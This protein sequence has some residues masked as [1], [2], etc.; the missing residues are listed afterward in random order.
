MDQ[1]TRRIIGFATHRGDVTGV[2]LCCLFNKIIS[3]KSLPKYLSSDNDPLFT[4]HRW[5]ANLRIL[6]VEE[7]KST[8][9]VP[10]S[11]PFVERVIGTIRR[12]LLDHILFWN[13]YDL[14]CKL[15]S[16]QHY[17][18]NERGHCGIDGFSPSQKA[19]KQSRTVMSIDHYRWRKYCCGLFELPTAA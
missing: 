16:F 12:E 2:D 8:P 18:N 19:K 11:H 17:Y 4:F 9:Q 7:I 14:Q 10:T 3:G 1:F 6:N 5:Q 13:A 15:D